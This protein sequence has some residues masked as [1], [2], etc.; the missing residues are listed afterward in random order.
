MVPPNVDMDP[1]LCTLRFRQSPAWMRQI[2]STSDSVDWFTSNVAGSSVVYADILV[3]LEAHA[4]NQW[5]AIAK[6]HEWSKIGRAQNLLVKPPQSF[7]WYFVLG[8]SQG[9]AMLAWPAILEIIGGQITTVSPDLQKTAVWLT[10]CD[11]NGWKGMSYEWLSPIGQ[12]AHGITS[13]RDLNDCPKIVARPK[14]QPDGIIQVAARAACWDFG[15]QLVAWFCKAVRVQ[16]ANSWSLF[17]CLQAF[18]RAALPT[19]SE[20]E[21]LEIMAQRMTDPN[22]M[23]LVLLSEG[24]DDLIADDDKATFRKDINKAQDEF[25]NTKKFKEAWVVEKRRRVVGDGSA[26]ARNVAFSGERGAIEECNWA[27]VAPTLT[28]ELAAQLCPDLARI[29]LDHANCRWQVYWPNLASRSRNFNLHGF[30]ESC[31]M[32]LEWAW[33]EALTR[34]GLEPGDCPVKGLIRRASG[35]AS[36]S[37]QR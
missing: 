16:V 22:I 10:M 13:W 14:D 17:R 24:A 35:G 34:A 3:M 2:V 26:N 18:I 29:Y 1:D 12:V 23:D 30:S 25:A 6:G 32:V 5:A 11:H 36:S 4:T 15:R 19:L 21:V 7:D 8:D 31:R 20:E 9:V 37:A 33:V 28:K 27:D